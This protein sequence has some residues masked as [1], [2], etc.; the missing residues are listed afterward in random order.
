MVFLKY[1]G[2]SNLWAHPSVL[3]S[4]SGKGDVTVLMMRLEF[5]IRVFP[6]QSSSASMFAT[7]YKRPLVESIRCSIWRII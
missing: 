3:L 6:N 1:R 5:N 4:S 2:G 7:V